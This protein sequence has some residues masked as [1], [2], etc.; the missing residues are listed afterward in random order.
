M[1]SIKFD[2]D[3][4]LWSTMCISGTGNIR[5]WGIHQNDNPMFIHED[6]IDDEMYDW[7][8]L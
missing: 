7:C 2:K 1:V 8:S 5:F 4:M 6:L 3:V